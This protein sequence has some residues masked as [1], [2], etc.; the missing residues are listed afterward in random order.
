LLLLYP[1]SITLLEL[2]NLCYGERGDVI[3]TTMRY[4]RYTSIYKT[5]R[6]YTHVHIRAGRCT[7]FS[8]AHMHP[9]KKQK[10]KTNKKQKQ[11]KKKTSLWL[12]SIWSQWPSETL[13]CLCTNQMLIAALANPPGKP[14]GGAVP[15]PR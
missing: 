14:T 6:M 10:Q 4:T 11:N 15:C 9:C 13:T 12:L 5:E 8:S 2:V 1:L 7:K 3:T